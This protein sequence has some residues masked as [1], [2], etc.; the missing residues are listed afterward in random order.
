M[1]PHVQPA[2]ATGNSHLSGHL[3]ILVWL[4]AAHQRC[5]LLNRRRLLRWAL[6]GAGGRRGGPRGRRCCLGSGLVLDAKTT[7][8]KPFTAAD[9]GRR[10]PPDRAPQLAVPQRR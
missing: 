9:P 8:W 1:L 2:I 3:R 4:L 5:S 6:H 10:P 7:V